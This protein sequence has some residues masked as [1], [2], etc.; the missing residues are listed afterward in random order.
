MAIVLSVFLD[1]RILITPFGILDL[2][3]LITSLWYLETIHY[4]SAVPVYILHEK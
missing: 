1:L 2:R 4:N 3:I